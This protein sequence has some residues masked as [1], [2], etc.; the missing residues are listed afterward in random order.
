MNKL[1]QIILGVAM[2][3]WAQPAFA[4]HNFFFRDAG[5]IVTGILSGFRLDSS[6]ITKL[7]P[8]ING[9]GREIDDNSLI[10]RN[11][12]FST[13]LTTHVAFSIAGLRVY[14]IVIA[15]DNTT[16]SPDLYG[17]DRIPFA[18]AASSFNARGRGSVFVRRGTYTVENVISD[19]IDWICEKGVVF[20]RAN[21]GMM[22]NIRNGGIYNAVFITTAVADTV[23]TTNAIVLEGYRPV[24]KDIIFEG[25]VDNKQNGNVFDAYNGFIQITSATDFLLDN[26][27]ISSYSNLWNSGSSRG[28]G[29]AIADSTGVIRNCVFNMDFSNGSTFDAAVGFRNSRIDFL[30]NVF[31]ATAQAVGLLGIDYALRDSS[32]YRAYGNTFYI[33]SPYGG[34]EGALFDATNSTGSI[35]QGNTFISQNTAGI[36]ICLNDSGLNGSGLSQSKILIADNVLTSP[37]TIPQIK[38]GTFA[39]LRADANKLNNIHFSGNVVTIAGTVFESETGTVSTTTFRDNRNSGFPVTD[40]SN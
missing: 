5:D 6:S 12:A 30:Y 21:N 36:A 37:R 1:K 27:I 18:A 32:Y 22:F 40:S 19:G 9:D 23:I 2:L 10:G 39:V 14:A 38:S 11:I 24:L 34:A 25:A 7:G 28:K 16:G 13:I 4:Y 26:V 29:V 31:N 3:A 33:N 17:T 20:R 8:T 35:I 15:T